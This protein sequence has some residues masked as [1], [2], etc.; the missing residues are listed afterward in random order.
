M[1]KL[2]QLSNH[3]LA[4]LGELTQRE[5]RFSARDLAGKLNLPVTTTAKILKSLT[6]SGILISHRGTQG[7]YGLA[8]EPSQITVAE[9]VASLE[10]PICSARKKPHRAGELVNRAIVRALE[11][12]SLYEMAAE[13]QCQTPVDTNEELES[14]IKESLEGES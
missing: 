6:R 14:E 4:L 10:G 11:Q 3:A 7:G 9:I 13:M 2:T 1:L 12:I 8:K 5:C